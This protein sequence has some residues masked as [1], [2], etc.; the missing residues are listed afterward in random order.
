MSTIYIIRHAHKEHGDY[1]NPRL[2]HQ[3]E[4]ITQQGQEQARRLWSYFCDKEISAIYVSAYRRT[5][6]TIEYVSKQREIT[7]IMD[8]RLNEIDNG[9]IEGMS[10]AEIQQ[11]YP[12]V[13]RGFRERAADFRFPEGET[14]EEARQR[15]ADFLEEKRQ[16]HANE[17]LIVVSHE[18]LIRLMACE[19]LGLPVYQRWNFAV[20]FCG[21]MEIA[22]QP[23][24]N[25]WKLL[26]FNRKL[27]QAG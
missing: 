19:I 3:D 26:R 12:Q 9:L 2:R 10:E 1:Y 23:E 14:G 15:I 5:R 8:A 11:R 13:W 18:G 21:I 20:D 25:S 16:L 17:N 24:Y 6:E 7:P 22:Y 4:P 27:F